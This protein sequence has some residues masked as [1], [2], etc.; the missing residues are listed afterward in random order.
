[1]SD[2][3]KIVVKSTVTVKKTSDI[4]QVAR[5]AVAGLS[6]AELIERNSIGTYEGKQKPRV[7][8]DED[9]DNKEED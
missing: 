5:K 1:M 7:K 2:D 3:K 6:E 8:K 4:R 9:E